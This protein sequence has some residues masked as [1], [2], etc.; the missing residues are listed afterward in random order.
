MS[1][2]LI[3][4]NKELMCKKYGWIFDIK[5]VYLAILSL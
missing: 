3:Y 5:I 1:N 4:D 2:L